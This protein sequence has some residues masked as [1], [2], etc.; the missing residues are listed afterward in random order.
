MAHFVV[1]VLSDGTDNATLTGADTDYSVPALHHVDVLIWNQT[2]T[3]VDV[4]LT[5][6]HADLLFFNEVD[7]HLETKLLNQ[8]RSE[9]VNN[10]T[11]LDVSFFTVNGLAPHSIHPV[12]I[13]NSNNTTAR[14][15]LDEASCTMQTAGHGTNVHNGEF[16]WVI[17][18]QAIPA[19]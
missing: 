10:G 15:W 6:S 11:A 19:G 7:Q 14:D 4:T 17:P 8:Y 12:R 9:T 13:T 5:T 1:D 18:F 16:V 2:S 3:P